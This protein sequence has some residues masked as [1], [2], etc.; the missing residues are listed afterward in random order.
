MHLCFT[1]AA[2]TAAAWKHRMY[3]CLYTLSLALRR[4]TLAAVQNSCT[5]LPLRSGSVSWLR[6]S[7]TEL[8]R[9]NS[10][11]ADLGP[12]PTSDC[13]ELKT[14]CHLCVLRANNG[15]L[16]LLSDSG[17]RSGCSPTKRICRCSKIALGKNNCAVQHRQA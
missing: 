17:Y 1:T 3:T 15:I 14:F 13:D 7:P 8:I 2:T 5:T 12:T 4:R 6:F 11:P 16:S 9:L 10:T